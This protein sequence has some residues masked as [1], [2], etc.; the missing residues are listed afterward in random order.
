MGS[1][2]LF[3]AP[4]SSQ[5]PATSSVLLRESSWPAFRETPL[6]IWVVDYPR[7][8]G[9]RKKYR[10]RISMMGTDKRRDWISLL[11]SFN[12]IRDDLFHPWLKFFGFSR[13]EE[14]FDH[15]FHG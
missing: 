6:S 3:T 14:F 1:L 8:L 4:S 12:L 10:P 13:T 2:C 15:G 11:R 7:S 9:I 5:C